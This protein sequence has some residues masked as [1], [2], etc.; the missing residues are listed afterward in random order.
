MDLS[1]VYTNDPVVVENSNTIEKLLVEDDKY[2]VVG[3]DLEYAGSRA[4][5]ANN[6]DY[7]F[8]MVDTTNDLKVLKTLG[9]VCE[10]LVNIQG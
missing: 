3:F 7:R 1:V 4:S 2:K 10:K 8:T 5:F 6:P 9:L